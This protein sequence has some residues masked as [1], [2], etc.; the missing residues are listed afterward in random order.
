MTTG[1]LL[2]FMVTLLQGN[3]PTSYGSVGPFKDMASCDAAG[4]AMQKQYAATS[5]VEYRC[6]RDRE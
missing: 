4:K 2:V 3:F 6:L 5:R 1:I